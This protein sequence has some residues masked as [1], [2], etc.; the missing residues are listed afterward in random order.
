[1]SGKPSDPCEL[2]EW[3]TAFFGFRIARAR[4]R[5][6]DEPR[7]AEIDAWCR[8]NQVCC[9]YFLACPDCADSTRVAEQHDF[10][11]VDIRM[12]LE[13]DPAV[14]PQAELGRTFAGEI[15]SAR[16][17]DMPALQQIARVSHTDT[18]FFQ[19]PH[20]A[21]DR[22]AALYE[23]WIKVSL[24]GYAHAVLVAELEGC[25]AGYISCHLESTLHE[26]RIGLLGVSGETRGQ[27]VGASLVSR[28][29]AW[30]CD[31]GVRR[32]L[33]ATQGRNV[34]AQRLYQRCGFVTSTV[35]LWYHKWY[36]SPGAAC[37]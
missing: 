9:I 36:G 10:R 6:L 30:F 12:T 1:M 31:Q 7:A 35:D 17:A 33:V 8:R 22:S 5:L 18:R 13:R 4:E 20:F 25:P 3:D 14:P 34:R 28:A 21:K 26:G 19:D 37:E 27:G 16:P 24:E 32:V 29:L 2:L 15:R 23:T 11:L